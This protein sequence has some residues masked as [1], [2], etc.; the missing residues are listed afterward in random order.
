MAIERGKLQDLVFDNRLLWS[1]RALAAM[2]GVIL[3]LP[4]AKRLLAKEQ[5]RSPPGFESAEQFRDE[6]E[7][8]LLDREEKARKLRRSGGGFLGVARVLAQKPTTRPPPGEPRRG[9]SPRVAGRDKWKRIEVLGRLVEFL[10]SY[11]S[12]WAARCA[13]ETH[14]V[15]PFG[16]YQL[17]VLHGVP[18]AGCG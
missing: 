15:F 14:V 5:V 12:A 4:P 17:R 2:L 6:L 13:S 18:C 7:R 10:R 9:L 8:T 11:R 16:T 1:H 3:R